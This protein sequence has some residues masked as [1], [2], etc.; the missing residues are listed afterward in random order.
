MHTTGKQKAKKP[1][2]NCHKCGKVGHNANQCLI[3]KPLIR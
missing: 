1:D 2:I 3:K